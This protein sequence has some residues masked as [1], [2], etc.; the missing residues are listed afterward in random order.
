MAKKR[1]N[2]SSSS[3]S[4]NEA[5]RKLYYNNL[6]SD[7]DFEI[8]VDLSADKSAVKEKLR[9]LNRLTEFDE[10]RPR[11]SSSKCSKKKGSKKSY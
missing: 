7:D 4:Y 3:V 8:L 2:S 11:K 6:I 1:S 9:T 10:Y 5:I